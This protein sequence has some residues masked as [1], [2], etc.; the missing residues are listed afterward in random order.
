[1]GLGTRWGGGRY[2]K[3]LE[4]ESVTIV[5]WKR[6][7]IE[8]RREGA[9]ASLSKRDQEQSSSLRRIKVRELDYIIPSD[10]KE[11]RMSISPFPNS[12]HSFSFG[13]WK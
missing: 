12:L 6:K 11:G 4:R 13:S 7:K 9:R 1:M 8:G 10:S 2:M 5:T 3:P